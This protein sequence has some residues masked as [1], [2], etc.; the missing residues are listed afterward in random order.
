[1]KT[2]LLFPLAA[3]AL[4]AGCSQLAPTVLKKPEPVSTIHLTL[5]P[6]E[7]IIT[8]KPVTVMAKLNNTAQRRTLTNDDLDVVHTQPFHL[9]V[10]DESLTD[11]QH[12]H[13]QP[14]STPGIYSFSFTPKRAAVY[15]AWADITPKDTHVQEFDMADLGS[16]RAGNV[17]LPVNKTESLVADAGGYHFVLSFDKPLVEG[18]ESIG[19][20][21]V[22][23]YKENAFNGL[24]PVMGAYAHIVGFYDNFS[25]VIHTHP[26]GDEPKAD[27]DRGGPDLVFHLETPKPGFIK[28]FAQVHVKN[29]DVYVPFG[30]TVAKAS[31]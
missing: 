16:R 31:K 17:P 21:H 7:Q 13:P 15:R 9:L 29:H 12:I 3:C 30:V 14:T 8:G 4:A 1:M 2:R 19:T 5:L 10:V 27:S 18:G 20:I 24:E 23:D 6:Q 25:T 26:L 22:T 28:L 11:Y